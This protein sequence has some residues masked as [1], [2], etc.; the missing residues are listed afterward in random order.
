M[1]KRIDQN[2]QKRVADLK[3]R[4]R[5]AVDAC[6]LDAVFGE[7]AL[8]REQ[9]AGDL[10]NGTPGARI[11]VPEQDIIDGQAQ[12]NATLD[13]ML[14][15]AIEELINRRTQALAEAAKQDALTGLL[16][17]AAFDDHLRSELTRAKRYDRQF[18]LA[19]LDIDCLK[20]VNDLFGHLAGDEVLK[21]VGRIMQ[22]SLRRSDFVFRYGGDEFAAICP[23]TTGAA[24]EIVFRRVESNIQLW[25]SETLFAHRIGVSWGLSSYPDQ[26]RGKDGN[27]MELIRIADEQLYLCKKAHHKQRIVQR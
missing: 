16:N 10:K 9:I 15:T 13:R 17:R 23:E 5:A 14:R 6:D 1:T 12:R 21:N 27:E 4:L 18:S 24:V 22:A 19:L 26:G 8:I 20:P 11:S 3:P 2:F 25:A 7:F